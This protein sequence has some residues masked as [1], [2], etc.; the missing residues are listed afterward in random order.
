MT[1]HS[2]ITDYINKFDAESQRRLQLMRKLVGDIVPD[3]IETL[4]Y[5]LIAYKLHS[6]PLVYFGAF[7][8]HVGLYA[9]P[10]GHEAFKEDFSVYK[11]GKGS[12]QFP[13]SQPLP[14]ELVQRIIE[15]RKNTII[16]SY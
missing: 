7:K 15:Y 12:V 9:T 10:N 13:N 2:D 6:K 5:G 4:S 3:A 1:E 14:L 11:K 8:K 16:S